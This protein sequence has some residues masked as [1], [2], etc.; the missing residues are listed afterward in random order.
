MAGPGAGCGPEGLASNLLSLS[1]RSQG[2]CRFHIKELA[3]SV[4]THSKPAQEYV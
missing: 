4:L 1:E 3:E 2:N